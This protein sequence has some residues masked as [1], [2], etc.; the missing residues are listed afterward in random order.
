MLI[1]VVG[2]SGA[3]KDTVLGLAHRELAGDPRFRFVRRV[4]T[5]KTHTAREDHVEVTEAEFSSRDFALQ[6]RVHGLRYGLPSDI[7]DAIARGVTVVAN[8][9]RSV[10]ADAALRFPTRVIQITA[11]PEL[12]AERLAGRA[13]ET[14]SEI[15]QR[16]SRS[17]ALPGGVPGDT[18]KND[19]TPAE[20]AAKFIALLRQYATEGARPR[21]ERCG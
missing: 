5:R 21:L 11:P 2:P 7:A 14:S 18:V 6:W 9:S 20:A 17:V 16:L 19:A 1:L 15:R 3:G 13:R 8:V 12:L 4:I 10:I